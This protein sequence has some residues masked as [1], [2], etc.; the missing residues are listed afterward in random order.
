V[1]ELFA[2]VL[3][4]LATYRIARMLAMEEGPFGLFDRVRAR[5]DP[6]QET[7]LGRGL[8]CP[9]CIGFWVALLFTVL[10]WYQSG[11]LIGWT[12][13]HHSEFLLVWFALAGAQELAHLWAER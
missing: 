10:L 4:V 8:N 2:L 12:L 5:I 9:L 7:W 3:A 1:P 6:D 11:L 13:V